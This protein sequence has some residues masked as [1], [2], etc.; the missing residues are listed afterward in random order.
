MF[1][2][3][4][5]ILRTKMAALASGFF[6]V[7]VASYGNAVLGSMPTSMLIY[8]SMALMLNAKAFDQDKRDMQPEGLLS[9]SKH[10]NTMKSIQ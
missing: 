4:D 7:M 10:V 2:I 9:T 5:P 8:T 1:R 3:R 6:G